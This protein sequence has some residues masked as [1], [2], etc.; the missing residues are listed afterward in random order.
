MTRFTGSLYHRGVRALLL[1]GFAGDPQAW[2]GFEGD[3]IAMP[4]HGTPLANS[5]Q[6]NLDAID[7]KGATLAI[8]Y[9]FGARVALGLLASKR[10]ERAILI[11]VNPGIP[12]EDRPAR[13]T[14]DARWAHL[15]RERGI[16]AFLEAWEAQPLFATQARVPERVAAR[17]ARRLALDPEQLARCLETMG[18]AEMP[19]YRGVV[20]RATLIAGAD[21]AKF[22]ALAGDRVIAIP[23][24][25]HDVLL[26]QPE[27]L[28]AVL[29]RIVRAGDRGS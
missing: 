2:D 21:D 1:H 3:A 29:T 27:A 11:G 6:A 9:S 10:I 23:G 28:A 14:A 26:E 7:T 16:E 18:L 5:W 19:D 8:G 13:R 25:G 24:A 22:L 17:R 12:D 4:G 15:L 20:G